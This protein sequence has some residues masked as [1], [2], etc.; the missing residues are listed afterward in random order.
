MEKKPKNIKKVNRLHP[1]N[2]GKEYHPVTGQLRPRPFENE[3]ANDWKWFK[4]KTIRGA[5]K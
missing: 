1:L 4:P 5:K 3:R 2:G